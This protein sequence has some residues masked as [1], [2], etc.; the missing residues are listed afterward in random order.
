ML[1]EAQRNFSN[2]SALVNE[3]QEKQS[4]SSKTTKNFDN[5]KLLLKVAAEKLKEGA[6]K[7]EK[8]QEIIKN[9]ELE[10]KKLQSKVSDLSSQLVNINK[11]ASVSAVVDDMIDKNM[12]SILEKDQKVQD[13]MNMDD[14]ALEQLKL[15]VS[16][17]E[18]VDE[19]KYGIN[20]LQY[21]VDND[22]IQAK[23]TMLDSFS[24]N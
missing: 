23:K 1:T 21:I 2:L 17:V 12:V 9:L 10:N 24:G 20:S 11:T 22:I 4:L 15:A 5:Q 16:S 3:N 13:L 8:Y 19:E 14:T 18:K 6:D 7:F